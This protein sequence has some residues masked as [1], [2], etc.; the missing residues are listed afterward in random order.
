MD[1]AAFSELG[2]RL[3]GGR[4]SGREK[5]KVT[6]EERQLL[7]RLHNMPPGVTSN[8]SKKKIRPSSAAANL[9]THPCYRTSLYG[10]RATATGVPS[11]GPT[12]LQRPKT[13]AGGPRS[14]WTGRPQVAGF[15]AEIPKHRRQTL[16]NVD[17]IAETDYTSRLRGIQP[18]VG[19]LLKGKASL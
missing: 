14:L 6:G 17:G 10:D 16:G 13:Q 12:V 9:Q 18:S 11:G 15:D 7:D 5:P 19:S 1:S 4:W 3:F 2:A 8:I